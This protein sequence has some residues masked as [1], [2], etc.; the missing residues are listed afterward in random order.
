MAE[1]TARRNG[2]RDGKRGGGVKT[3]FTHLPTDQVKGTMLEAL[4][5][6]LGCMPDGDEQWGDKKHRT[7]SA[8][9]WL[10]HLPTVQTAAQPKKKGPR[11]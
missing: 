6:T 7:L 1:R 9:T 10:E 11:E 2:R 4:R 3:N 5:D 8:I